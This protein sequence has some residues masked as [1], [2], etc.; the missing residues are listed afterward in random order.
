M[1]AVSMRLRVRI[2][3]AGARGGFNV[4]C[5]E[6]SLVT[7]GVQSCENKLNGTFTIGALLE[8]A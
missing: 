2:D 8:I 3:W 6:G 7:T 1:K 5:L 4:F